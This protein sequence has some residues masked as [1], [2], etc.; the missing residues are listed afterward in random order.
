[1]NKWKKS[2]RWKNTV[3]C[4]YYRKWSIDSIKSLSKFQW[5]FHR[6]NPTFLMRSHKTP[7]SQRNL[8]QKQSQ[9]ISPASSLINIVGKTEY[10]HAELWNWGLI[11]IPQTKVSS[12]WIRD[13]NMKHETIKLLKENRGKVLDTGHSNFLN[14]WLRM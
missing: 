3:K 1:M 14:I 6:N 11:S 5:F 10:L 7:K 4:S 2:H 8:H 13:L 12:E 9:E